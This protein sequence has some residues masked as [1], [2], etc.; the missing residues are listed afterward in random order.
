MNKETIV[1]S[2]NI[3]VAELKFIKTNKFKKFP[4]CSPDYPFFH[5]MFNQKIDLEIDKNK[6]SYGIRYEIKKCF[7]DRYEKQF[8]GNY[9]IKDYWIPS[10]DLEEF[11]QNL[12]GEIKITSINHSE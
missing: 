2:R 6:I 10:K 3:T 4:P 7:L 1:F 12:I 5:T 11:N 8:V 9:D